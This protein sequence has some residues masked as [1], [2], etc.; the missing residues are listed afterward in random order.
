MG[1]RILAPVILGDSSGVL[2]LGDRPGGVSFAVG[3]MDDL[4]SADSLR[5][6]ST[7]IFHSLDYVS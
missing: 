5:G 3:P 1:Y 2:V 7:Q 6:S 4:Q